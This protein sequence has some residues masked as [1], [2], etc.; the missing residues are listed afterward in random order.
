MNDFE[1]TF[2]AYQ[3][4]EA[5]GDNDSIS[6]QYD[7]LKRRSKAQLNLLGER[8][9]ELSLIDGRRAQNLNILLSRY[10]LSEEHIHS[11]VMSMDREGQLDK[12]MVEQLI[13]YVPT[14]TERELLESHTH[15]TSNFA[16][17]DR[18]MLVTSR[19][20]HVHVYHAPEGCRC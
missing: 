12:D 6:T 1:N 5:A 19:C 9:K 11:M 3:Q 16:R 2:S 10:K 8:P 14:S 13:K 18:F 20:A 7:T 4:K 17:A 15:E